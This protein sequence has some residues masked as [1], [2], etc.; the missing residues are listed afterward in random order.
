MTE[1]FETHYWQKSTLNIARQHMTAQLLISFFSGSPHGDGI[2]QLM[3]SQR[4]ADDIATTAE[5][6]QQPQRIVDSV[7]RESSRMGMKININKSGGPTER[8]RNRDMQL[9]TQEQ[10]NKQQQIGRS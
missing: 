10:N 6:E 1:W 3:S 7:D 5:S 4:F 2:G 8:K 9:T